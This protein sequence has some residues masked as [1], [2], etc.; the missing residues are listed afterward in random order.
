MGKGDVD[1]ALE[2]VRGLISRAGGSNGVARVV[3][4]SGACRLTRCEQDDLWGA[5]THS[6]AS[7]AA[8]RERKELFQA[9]LRY[10]R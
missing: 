6:G 7:L 10:C 1:A 9:T 3:H 4:C 2:L 5:E 8:A